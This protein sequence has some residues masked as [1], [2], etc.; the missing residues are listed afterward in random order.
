[1][2]LT[3][4]FLSVDD[5]IQ[6]DCRSDALKTEMYDHVAIFIG[7]HLDRA[8]AA[9]LRASLCE[10]AKGRYVRYAGDVYRPA[11]G[12]PV[13]VGPCLVGIFPTA[14]DRDAF[15][16][17]SGAHPAQFARAIAQPD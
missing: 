5:K 3:L 1:M 13:D 12:D 10:L 14:G 11:H 17:L 6:A 9:M 2:A 8:H 16:L 4:Q 15:A 7:Q